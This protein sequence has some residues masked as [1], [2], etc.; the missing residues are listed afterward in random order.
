VISAKSLRQ[1]GCNKGWSQAAQW[2]ELAII[3]S[4]DFTIPNSSHSKR[5]GGP[6]LL[7]TKSF[8]A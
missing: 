5:D 1:D 3:P 7:L 2:R 8:A 6:R 4:L